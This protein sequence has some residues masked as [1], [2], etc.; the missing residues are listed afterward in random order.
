MDY[1]LQ[2]IDF[3]KQICSQQNQEIFCRICSLDS[4]ENII[5]N[6]TG[7]IQS[8]SINLDGTS[9]IRRTCQ[10]VLLINDFNKKN[11]NLK[12]NMK[13]KI[14]IGIKN[15]TNKYL[16]SQII[17]FPVGIYY[18]TNFTINKTLQGNTINL[19]AKDKMIKLTGD[20]GGVFNSTVEFDSINIETDQKGIFQKNKINL[21]TLITELIH[22]YGQE[23]YEKIFIYD[24]DDYGLNSI[25]YQGEE[26]V[27]VFLKE[28]ENK[29]KVVNY[30]FDNN[31]IINVHNETSGDWEEKKL[32]DLT[33]DNKDFFVSKYNILGEEQEYNSFYLKDDFEHSIPYYIK[34]CNKGDIIGYELTELI[35]SDNL[36]GAP[37][38]NVTSILNKILNIL[39]KNNYEYYYDLNGNFIF[40]KQDQF[41]KI[42]SFLNPYIS[43]QKPTFSFRNNEL[44]SSITESFDLS[45]IKNDFTVWGTRKNNKEQ[46]FHV[47]IAID[48]KPEKYIS[49]NINQEKEKEL[50]E[51]YPDLYGKRAELQQ[52]SIYYSVKPYDSSIWADSETWKQ[53][54]W[55]EIIYQMAQDYKKFNQLSDFYKLIEENNP[56]YVNG[57]TGYERYYIDLD[58]F[59]RYLY[60]L[61]PEKIDIETPLSD[62]ISYTVDLKNPVVYFPEMI[63][64]P[65]GEKITIKRNYYINKINK[66]YKDTE[67]DISY[68]INP[69]NMENQI[70]YREKKNQD[71]LL[72]YESVGTLNEII[73]TNYKILQKIYYSTN[74]YNDEDYFILKDIDTNNRQVLNAGHQDLLRL[75]SDNINLSNKSDQEKM[76][77]INNKEWSYLKKGNQEPDILGIY[78]DITSLYIQINDNIKYSTVS[79]M[80][81]EIH[82]FTP[83]QSS[84][85]YKKI[86]E[87]P[88]NKYGYDLT[89]IQDF[90]KDKNGLI[91]W[92]Q[93]N[94]Q[95]TGISKDINKTTHY[96]NKIY[97][98]PANLIFWFD[99]LDNA[100][101]S[102]DHSIQNIGPREYVQ[103]KSNVN[104]IVNI[105]TLDN[106]FLNYKKSFTKDE[107]NIKKF[108]ETPF[109][110]RRYEIPFFRM[111]EKDN[112][113]F[114]ISSNSTSALDIINNYIYNNNYMSSSVNIKALPQYF[115]Q[116]NTM[117][118]IID[119]ENRIIIQ[120]IINKINFSF[121]YSFNNQM[122]I[123]GIKLIDL[124]Y[125]QQDLRRE[126]IDE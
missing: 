41:V 77:T 8:G 42:E 71:G 6:L 92:G 88:K 87:Y 70:V 29:V 112:K 66:I 40:K 73:Q 46:Q 54:D 14:E 21:K 121:N 126:I 57:I 25:S 75:I 43:F 117:F 108:F 78:Y 17:W 89:N 52:E 80:D 119:L 120:Y 55:R 28:E 13:I 65:D 122:T 111:A 34:K 113:L 67:K 56:E 105:F 102:V 4:Y 81:K 114:K 45:K 58:G 32:T 101:F 118:E 100:T 109:A 91:L 79:E 72:Y 115:L 59:W 5:N 95:L 125:A 19:S 9:A 64:D 12:T 3:L 93:A 30:M 76:N 60:V 86:E 49:L 104:S 39:G 50:K 7:I 20:L 53:V 97:N 107:E 11:I 47:R 61:K 27:Y 10:L 44:L 31:Y 124:N 85:Y 16:N 103:S 38:E 36:I 1:Y 84:Q 24:L 35:Y 63:K 69:V 110:K 116:P 99:F 74:R 106:I 98:D 2:D 96:N 94:N 18:L 23:P 15:F 37:G 68:D 83:T 51:K 90:S 33:S 26:P 48:K 62:D 22:T 82:L 123:D